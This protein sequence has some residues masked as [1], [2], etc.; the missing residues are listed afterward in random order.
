[1]AV[2]AEEHRG[3]DGTAVVCPVCIEKVW[4]ANSAYGYMRLTDYIEEHRDHTRPP[5]LEA[6]ASVVIGQDAPA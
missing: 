2:Y 6:P 1:M 5:I 4:Y 3:Q